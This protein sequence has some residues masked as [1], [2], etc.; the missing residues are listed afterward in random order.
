M[1]QGD[2]GIPMYHP[3]PVCATLRESFSKAVF[4]ESGQPQRLLANL[5][6]SPATS[7]PPIKILKP[8]LDWS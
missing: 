1:I 5:R 3:D 2:N 7:E 4:F 8:T 6:G